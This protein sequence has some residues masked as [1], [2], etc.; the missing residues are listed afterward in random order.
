ML[1]QNGE[2]VGKVGQADGVEVFLKVASVSLL[3][4]II[5]IEG[6]PSLIAG[7]HRA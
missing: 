3:S 7:Y 6:H 1:L 4:L 2:V 5:T